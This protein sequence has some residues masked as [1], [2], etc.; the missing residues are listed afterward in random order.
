MASKINADTSGGLKLTSDTSGVIEFQ[1]A[2][3]TKAGV[4]GTGLTGD[5]SQV[6][7]LNAAAVTSG[8]LP[9]ARLSGTLPALNGSNLTGIASATP[10]A[11]TVL[12]TDTFSSSAYVWTVVTGLSTTAIT[13]TTSGSKFLVS[14]FLTASGANNNWARIERSIGGG[15]WTAIAVGD[16]ASARIQTMAMIGQVRDGGAIHNNPGILLDAPA[17][18]STVEYR[19]AVLPQA[20]LTVIYINRSVD[21]TD[22][23]YIARSAS[24]LTVLEV[25][26]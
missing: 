20:A 17:T 11:Q 18:T 22:A 15:T 1:S 19:W 7:A 21:D 12:K 9:M 4:N 13:P 26:A 6:T 24:A 25:L 10:Q 23:N 5:A 2:G 14:G 3:T 16:A 8:I